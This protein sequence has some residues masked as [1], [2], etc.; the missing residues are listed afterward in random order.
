LLLVMMV[1]LSAVVMD[2][3]VAS[4]TLKTFKAT[5]LADGSIKVEWETASEIDTVAFRVYRSQSANTVGQVVATQQAQGS[6]VT[7]A[8]YN[9]TDPASELIAGRNYYYRLE[10]LTSSGGTS[11]HGP[12]NPGGTSAGPTQ[13][14][15]EPTF[16]DPP[17]ATRRY[18]NTPVP[19]TPLP[20]TQ[21]IPVQ[22]TFPRPTAV[23]PGPG[24]VTTPTGEPALA[25]MLPP[26]ATP[27]LPTLSPTPPPTETLTLTP[28]NTPRPTI[29]PTLTSAPA[30]F[31]ARAGDETPTATASLAATPQALAASPA[32]AEGESLPVGVM[33]GAALAVGAALGLLALGMRRTRR[34]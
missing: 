31:V 12:V 21:V 3:A 27:V 6:S 18:T 7:G 4:I 22:P 8:S 5:R 28:S 14:V 24:V 13:F 30:V 2:R 33:A 1:F 26:T 23:P 34:S 16:T 20:P 25:A 9:Y 11:W 15:I 32:S 19:P 10:E 17:T 29:T